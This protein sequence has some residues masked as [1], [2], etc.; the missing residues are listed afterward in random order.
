MLITDP[1]RAGAQLITLTSSSIVTVICNLG[2][3]QFQVW[4]MSLFAFRGLI[5]LQ[6]LRC[7]PPAAVAYRH[8]QACGLQCHGDTKP[9]NSRCQQR[10]H[11]EDS[12][13]F[14]MAM[15]SQGGGAQLITLTS[16]S[17]VTIICTTNWCW[18]A[19][20]GAPKAQLIDF[21]N[22]TPIHRSGHCRFAQQKPAGSRREERIQ[23]KL[24][25]GR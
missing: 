3:S 1:A 21:L 15:T 19:G 12:A 22:A 20:H 5:C 17:M 10:Y 18:N 8:Q 25:A 4:L 6:R 16:S 2:S 13:G 11:S 9:Q 24:P 14:R 23:R 7:Q